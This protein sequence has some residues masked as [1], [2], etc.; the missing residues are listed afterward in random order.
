MRCHSSVIVLG[1]FLFCP[2]SGSLHSTRELTTVPRPRTHTA[3]QSASHPTISAGSS[4]CQPPCASWSSTHQSCN[5][6]VNLHTSNVL[7]PGGSCPGSSD[8]AAAPRV[9]LGFLV[10]LFIFTAVSP[11]WPHT[12]I[13]LALRYWCPHSCTVQHLFY[14]A[15]SACWST[16]FGWSQATHAHHLPTPSPH[17]PIHNYCRSQPAAAIRPESIASALG[18]NSNSRRLLSCTADD[19]PRYKPQDGS[20]PPLPLCATQYF[21]AGETGK[22]NRVTKDTPDPMSKAAA[23]DLAFAWSQGRCAAVWGGVSVQKVC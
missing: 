10:L 17:T 19:E 4:L 14:A 2:L 6:T 18:S 7:K 5:Q 22:Y 11:P 16:H 20:S 1:S 8:A 9:R 15:P 23:A 13:R 12:H 21:P 3:I